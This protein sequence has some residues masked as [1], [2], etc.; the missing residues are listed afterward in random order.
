MTGKQLKAIRE[1]LGLSQGQFAERLKVTRVSVNRMENGMQAVTASME[2]LITLVAREVQSERIH[3]R[4][5]HTSG[6]EN[7]RLGDSSNL[8]V[9]RRK[10]QDAKK[11]PRRRST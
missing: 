5:A 8:R 10:Q 11:N 2:L 3:Q 7:K 6:D 9:H 1:K 4:T